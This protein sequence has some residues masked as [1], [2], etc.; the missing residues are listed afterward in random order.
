M[1]KPTDIEQREFMR[2]RNSAVQVYLTRALTD[3]RDLC[4]SNTD[5]EV[6]KRV[7]G[8]ARV[9]RDLLALIDPDSFSTN[10]K[11]G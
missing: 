3:A 2:L 8:Q 7:Q 10:G 11:R 5:M 1:I 4:V 9:Y 6:V